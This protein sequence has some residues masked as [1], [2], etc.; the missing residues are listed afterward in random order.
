M[1]S[2]LIE[3]SYFEVIRNLDVLIRHHLILAAHQQYS[4]DNSPDKSDSTIA[5][6]QE[7]AKKLRKLR[8]E[9][10]NITTGI[11]APY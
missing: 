5:D 8:E 2:D 7:K 1:Q 9:F 11:I 6:S 4:P 3:S 10:E